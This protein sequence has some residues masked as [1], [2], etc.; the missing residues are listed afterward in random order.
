MTL[1]IILALSILVLFSSPLVIFNLMAK[2]SI[3]LALSA[4]KVETFNPTTFHWRA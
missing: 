2:L 4:K 1:H 3:L